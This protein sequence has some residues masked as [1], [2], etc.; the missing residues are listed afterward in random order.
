MI[1]FCEKEAENGTISTKQHNVWLFFICVSNKNIRIW[2]V[3]CVCG[4]VSACVVW[5]VYVY[6]V[7][8]VCSGCVWCVY[9]CACILNLMSGGNDAAEEGELLAIGE[10]M[11]HIL[12]DSLPWEAR[13]DDGWTPAEEL[14]MTVIKILLPQ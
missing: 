6:V 3:K 2:S 10:R 8:I 1:T 4:G 14:T 13:D 12:L 9:L 5:C 7:F 11:E